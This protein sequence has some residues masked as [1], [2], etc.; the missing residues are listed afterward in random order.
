M[1][2]F[3]K[4]S[5]KTKLSVTFLLILLI[6]SL[7]IG[8][9]SYLTAT[10]QIKNQQLSNAETSIKLLNENISTVIEPKLNDAAQLATTTSTLTETQAIRQKLAEYLTMHPEASITYVGL[11]NGEM[12]R[13]PFYEYDSSYDPRERVWY[14]QAMASNDTIVTA[15]YISSSSGELVI[16]VAHKLAN[17]AGVYGIDMS[18]E[19][20]KGIANSVSIGEQ[21]F[22]TLLDEAQF[23][24]SK[25]DTESATPATE[26]YLSDIYAEPNGLL[27]EKDE[28][29]AFTTNEATNWKVIGTMPKSEVNKA[30]FP[31]MTMNLIVIFASLVF[32]GIIIFFI[33]RSILRPIQ[34]LSAHAQQLRDGDLTTEIT[35][36]TK[37]EIGE[38]ALAFQDMQQ[39]LKSV[40]RQVDD[41][42]SLVHQAADALNTSSSQVIAATEQTS[43]ATTEISVL[44]EAQMNGNQE[45]AASL[46]IVTK[47]I[48]SIAEHSN[49]VSSLTQEATAQAEIGASTI[50]RSVKQM[51]QIEQSVQDTDVTVRA[52]YDR[53][54]EINSILTVIQGI[55]EQT[56]LLALNASIEAARAGEHGKGFAVVAD[57]VRNLADDSK[58]ATNQISRLVTTIQAD[59]S[60]TVDRMNTT[61]ADVSEGIRVSN[62]STVRFE[63]IL[64]SMRQIAPTI[65]DVSATTQEITAR[66]QQVSA[67][68]EQL[69][70]KAQGNV[71]ATEEVATASEEVLASMEEMSAS[72][73]SLSTMSQEL[74]QTIYHFK[75]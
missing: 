24:I 28:L 48:M 25:P 17:N 71:Q 68:A 10:D 64:T 57:E 46:Q 60:K 6:P 35:I 1:S 73:E 29:V 72:A 20:L 62:E 74:K 67:T 37:D 55:A 42:S 11:S 61:L 38:L 7:V 18:I 59:T 63:Q 12:I 41:S 45:A 50:E 22:I 49:D 36:H 3:L 13:E 51:V 26:S 40:I 30:A 43:S 16:T 75:L 5:I 54:K 19:M 66:I 65:A 58:Q 14:K 39:N 21:G 56:N 31:I 69:T 9:F 47:Q 33:L 53:T 32:G 52:L 23:Y 15:P 34:Q 44:A 8:C 4:K 70:V 2:K 27:E